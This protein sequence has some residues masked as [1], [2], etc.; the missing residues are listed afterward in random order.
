MSQ[1]VI[2]GYSDGKPPRNN[3]PGLDGIGGPTGH[4][5]ARMPLCI[6]GHVQ[7]AK[8]EQG[9]VQAR[10]SLARGKCRVQRTEC[11][12]EAIPVYTAH[13]NKMRAKDSDSQWYAR[14]GMRQT[15]HF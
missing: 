9:L 6:K 10:R 7:E 15:E 2:L 4:F 12:R 8:F 1:I 13:K 11:A 5:N 14:L 3:L